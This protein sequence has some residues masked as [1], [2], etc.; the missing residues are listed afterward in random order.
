MFNHGKCVQMIELPSCAH[1]STWLCLGWYHRNPFRPVRCPYVCVRCGAGVLSLDSILY[2]IGNILWGRW[3]KPSGL[4]ALPVK[5]IVKELLCFGKKPAAFKGSAGGTHWRPLAP[6]SLRNSQSSTRGISEV[7][8]EK[9]KSLMY[10]HNED[11]GMKELEVSCV[12]NRC[13]PISL[14]CFFS[15]KLSNLSLDAARFV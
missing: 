10:S 13:F 14:F 5:L 8:V 12:V 11:N 3:T 6:T 2:S 9:L 7:S 4:I 15:P 1:L